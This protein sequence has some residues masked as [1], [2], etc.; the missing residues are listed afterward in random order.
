MAQAAHG[1][2]QKASR[3]FLSPT[4]LFN[5]SMPTCK[6]CVP[7]RTQFWSHFLRNTVDKEASFKIGIGERLENI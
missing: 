3:L 7:A 2:W 6:E 4:L 1:F 5:L